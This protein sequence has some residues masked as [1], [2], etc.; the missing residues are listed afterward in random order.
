MIHT[1]P[2]ILSAQDLAHIH[3]L[4]AKAPWE[5]GRS[6]AGAQAALV[7]NNQQLPHECEAAQF[8][9]Q[10]VVQ[11]LQQ[12]PLFLSAALPLRLFTPRVNRYTPPHNAYGPHVDGALRLSL[13]A[14]GS[15]EH[16]RTD[17]SCTVFI[18]PPEAYEGGE[19]CIHT[20]GATPQTRIKLPAGHAVLYPGYTLHEVSPVT[21]GERVACFLW[22][23]SL[24][25]SHEQR[26]LL[27]DMDMT[28]MALR[29]QHGETQATTRLT[30]TYH[31]LLRMWAE[32]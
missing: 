6:S 24:V 9:R 3:Q 21:Q 32:T 2:H 27:H 28:L 1:L 29:Q 10:R 17:L 14:D 22:V 26:E 11:G 16:V 7:K 23:Q 25:R 12:S 5:D 19:L 4:L 18:S 30:G 31:N 15:Q 8:I 20:H 13:K